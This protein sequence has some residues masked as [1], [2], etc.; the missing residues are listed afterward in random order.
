MDDKYRGLPSADNILTIRTNTME[1]FTETYKQVKNI[2][3]IDSQIVRM[4]PKFRTG[5][6]LVTPA[7]ESVTVIKA[8]IKITPITSDVNFYY[9]YDLSNGMTYTPNAPG[10]SYYNTKESYAIHFN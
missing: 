5:D 10:E 1:Y 3:S 2:S 6:T 8:Y 7:G 9:F 4:M